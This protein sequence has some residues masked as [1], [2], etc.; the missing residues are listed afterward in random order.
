MKGAKA[1]TVLPT[2]AIL[3]RVDDSDRD[4]QADRH[5]EEQVQKR[6][7]HFSSAIPKQVHGSVGIII[8]VTVPAHLDC[9]GEIP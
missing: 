9:A 2:L 6:S 3:G 4:R 5:Q 7:P 8:L 1:K